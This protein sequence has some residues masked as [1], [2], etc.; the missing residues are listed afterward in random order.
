MI[1]IEEF[2]SEIRDKLS[3]LYDLRDYNSAIYTKERGEDKRKLDK[4]RIY[5]VVKDTCPYKKLDI[6][7]I[8][9]YNLIEDE[10]ISKFEYKPFKKVH[11]Y[12]ILISI[13]DDFNYKEKIYTKIVLD[14]GNFDKTFL[15]EYGLTFNK[16]LK[17]Q[18]GK[19]IPMLSKKLDNGKWV[20]RIDFKKLSRMIKLNKTF[21]DLYQ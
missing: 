1:E 19:E 13:V 6:E 18:V 9:L 20:M 12:G 17:L 16:Y 15:F 11:Y 2:S 14:L 3:K 21:D 7:D 10:L 4:R 5:L 8:F